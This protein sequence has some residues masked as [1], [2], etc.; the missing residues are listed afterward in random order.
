MPCKRWG[1]IFPAYRGEL[2]KIRFVQTDSGTPVGAG[3]HVLSCAAGQ[4]SAG[5]ERV[6]LP[7]QQARHSRLRHAESAGT[8]KVLNW[9]TCRAAPPNSPAFLSFFPLSL[10]FAA[11]FFPP[12]FHSPCTLFSFLTF[13]LSL[14]RI[15]SSTFLFSFLTFSLSLPL[16]LP[17]S[18]SFFL[19]L[20]LSL[21]RSL[22]YPLQLFFS[23]S[24]PPG[25]CV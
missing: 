3:A 8:R 6:V 17:L 14:S 2:S 19:S 9:S 5:G 20:S 15:S 11:D 24:F 25:I 12:S 23:R 18:L 13:S 22:I 16:S 1:W 21:S 10:S 7:Q 4:L